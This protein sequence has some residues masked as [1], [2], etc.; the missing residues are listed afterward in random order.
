MHASLIRIEILF[1]SFF[2]T[3]LAWTVHGSVATV[4]V[5]MGLDMTPGN[6]LCTTPI[7]K[8]TFH[9][10]II[11]HIG[12]ESRY[13]CVDILRRS[14]AS[15]TCEAIPVGGSSGDGRTQAFLAEH[16]ATL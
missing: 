3:R 9:P 1:P 4:L 11:A 16:M 12:Q 14:P 7:R 5:N 8:R 10:D 13:I 15:G 6:N 2:I